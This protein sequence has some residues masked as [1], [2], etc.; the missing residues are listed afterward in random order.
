MESYITETKLIN[1]VEAII[2]AKTNDYKVFIAKRAPLNY[3]QYKAEI[4]VI[5]NLAC[6]Y[7]IMREI[8]ILSPLLSFSGS[9]VEANDE[10]GVDILTFEATL[11]FFD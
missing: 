6:S 9:G 2:K 3:S 10:R 11:E 4:C 1:K 5:V 7:E 8:M